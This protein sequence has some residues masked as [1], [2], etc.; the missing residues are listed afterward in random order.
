[1]SAGKLPVQ[2]CNE[3]KINS[4]RI[5]TIVLV[6]LASLWISTGCEEE[7]LIEEPVDLEFSADTLLF[8]TVFTSIGS[9]TRNFKVY[10]N[11]DKKLEIDRIKLGM[12]QNSP[13][14]INVNGLSGTDF[15]NMELRADDSLF[16][17]VEVTIDPNSKDQPMIVTDSIIFN[18]NGN[19]QDIKLVAWGQDAIFIVADKQIPGLPPFKIVAKEGQHVTWDDPKPYVI[20]GYA[21]VDSTASL[22]IREGTN[23]HFHAGSGLWV[24]KGGSLKVEGTAG[25]PVTFQGDRPEDQ[26][27]D[28]PG[29]WD[30]IWLNEGSLDNEISHAVIKNGFIGIQAEILDGHM[31]NKL[32]M[33]NVIIR[34]MTGIGILGRNYNIEASNIE[35][36][37]AGSYGM[38]LTNGGNYNFR[39]V[40]VANYWSE[41]VR[42]TPS[43]YLNN[44]YEYPDKTLV[45]N[46]LNATI[47]N[48]IIYG[49]QSNEFLAEDIDDGTQMSF[50]LDH[51]LVRTEENTSGSSWVNCIINDN[52]EFEDTSDDDYNLT[53]NSPA[54]NTGNPA[55]NVPVDLKGDMRDS[56]PDMG[57]YELIP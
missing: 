12:G 40:T 28:I 55:V 24:Y 23:V 16:I 14:R 30:R 6:I 56:Q 27:K 2:H 25:N 13:F 26:Y 44:F 41:S 51:C 17:F 22:T 35:V 47:S 45:S 43:V 31:G 1:M 11:R 57:A 54:V 33:D 19:I 5:P 37:N 39:H 4:L 8:D 46:D 21:V 42:Q 15:E 10:N 34:N 53:Q 52:P 50:T 18:T 49:N 48:S 36:S 7:K 38:A 9:A 29:Q 32:A 3:M 20:Y